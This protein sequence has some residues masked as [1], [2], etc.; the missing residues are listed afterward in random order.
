[1][2]ACWKIDARRKLGWMAAHLP[3]DASLIEIGSGPGSLLEVMRKRGYVIEGLDI[4]DSS[5]RPE[6]K[7][8][9]YDGVNMPF[10][11]K[12]YDIALLPTIL[13][14]TPDPDLIIAE[15]MRI[16]PCVIIIEDVYDNRVTEWLTKRLDSV[17]NLEFRGHP[18][19]NRTDQD[20]RECFK[21]NNYILRGHKVHRLGFIFKQ[22]VYVIETGAS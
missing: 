15:A 9:L 14:H 1:V 3:Q 16:A 17:L 10:A 18:H 8:R 5:F 7:P 11:D 19:S 21:A 2:F 6:L 4:R 22:A 12:S 13:H 20:W